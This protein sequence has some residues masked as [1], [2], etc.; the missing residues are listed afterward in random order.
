QRVCSY[1]PLRHDSNNGERGI[2]YLQF[3]SDYIGVA[4]KPSLP[5]RFADDDAEPGRVAALAVI[6]RRERAS[7]QR[8]RL[9]CVE[10]FPADQL[11]GSILGSAVAPHLQRLMIECKDL[12]KDFV[13]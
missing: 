12:K 1:K 7:Q 2:V 13:P 10:E 11:S 5:E 4:V 6:V 3:L 9:Q 8:W